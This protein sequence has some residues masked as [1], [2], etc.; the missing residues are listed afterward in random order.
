MFS[1]WSNEKA[2][3]ERHL[4]LSGTFSNMANATG[5]FSWMFEGTGSGP[6]ESK[7]M[8]SYHEC[9]ALIFQF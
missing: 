8:E 9:A 6:E 3:W 4:N 2:V 5:K 7:K 1:V